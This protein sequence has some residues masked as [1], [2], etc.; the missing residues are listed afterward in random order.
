MRDGVAM[1]GFYPDGVTQADIDQHCASELCS[2]CHQE[3]SLDG[4]C[5]CSPLDEPWEIDP[6]LLDAWVSRSE[7]FQTPEV[8]E[9]GHIVEGGIE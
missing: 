6:E 4:S 5:D 3:I 7:L 2:K 8:F 1:S 9:I